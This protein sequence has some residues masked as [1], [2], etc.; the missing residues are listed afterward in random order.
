MTLS[1]VATANFKLLAAQPIAVILAAPSYSRKEKIYKDQRSQEQNRKKRE[2]DV[3]VLFPVILLFHVFILACHIFD[4]KISTYLDMSQ[5]VL[6]KLLK[7]SLCYLSL[8]ISIL[9]LINQYFRSL[10]GWNSVT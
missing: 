3:D 4:K 10:V 6:T 8:K 9:L 7:N 2:F 5:T 1:T